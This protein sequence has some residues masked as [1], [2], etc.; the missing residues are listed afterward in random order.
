MESTYPNFCVFEKKLYQFKDIK[1]LHYKLLNICDRYQ[2]CKLDY[3]QERRLCPLCQ[4]LVYF[5]NFEEELDRNQYNLTNLKQFAFH[6][7]PFLE[8]CYK[9]D[10]GSP[11][12]FSGHYHYS[13]R[14][15]YT[16]QKNEI[17]SK[18]MIEYKEDL[19]KRNGEKNIFVFLL[20]FSFICK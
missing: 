7:F 17:S 19:K 11:E 6:L 4:I 14:D 10:K 18:D 13:L 3:N 8:E 12:A 9:V 1:E 2:G 16:R 20:I 15:Q 5:Q